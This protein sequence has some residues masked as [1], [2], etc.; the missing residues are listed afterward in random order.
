MSTLNHES[1]LEDC[2]DQAVE[3]FMQANKL[4]FEMFRQ[5]EDH[6]GVMLAIEKKALQIFEGMLQ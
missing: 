2:F 5:I 4:D 6:E 3:E 1:L